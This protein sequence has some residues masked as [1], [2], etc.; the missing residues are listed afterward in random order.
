M[1]R[2]NITVAK[3]ITQSK[4]HCLF[5]SW[6]LLW[7]VL[8]IGRIFLSPCCCFSLSTVSKGIF[9]SSHAASL[10]KLNTSTEVKFV[11]QS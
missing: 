8:I 7:V 2:M 6:V 9:T 10:I 1:R 4:V 5:M 3:V 11:T